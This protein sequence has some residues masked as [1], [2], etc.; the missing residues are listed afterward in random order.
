MA[1]EGLE[2]CRGIS[3]KALPV[4]VPVTQLIRQDRLAS[5][6][7]AD[8]IAWTH[9]DIVAVEISMTASD[10]LKFLSGCSSAPFLPSST[11]RRIWQRCK[12]GGAVNARMNRTFHVFV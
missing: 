9:D 5:H 3:A 6:C 1:L 8:K 11:Y 4:H 12:P 2:R 7:A 10:A